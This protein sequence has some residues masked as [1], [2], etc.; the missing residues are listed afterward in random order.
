MAVS[1]VFINLLPKTV[2][3]EELMLKI[4]NAATTGSHENNMKYVNFPWP[5]VVAAHDCKSIK[6][7]SIS[8]QTQL[9]VIYYIEEG[10]KA[11]LHSI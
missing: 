5:P 4:D 7:K 3:T 8:L 2:L 6:I 9:N 11:N 1:F 10:P